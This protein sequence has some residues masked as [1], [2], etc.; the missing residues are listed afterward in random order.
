[1]IDVSLPKIKPFIHKPD[2]GCPQCVRQ[3]QATA[4]ARQVLLSDLISL[5]D[6]SERPILEAMVQR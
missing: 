4:E 3:R 5:A 6:P 1:M 2:C